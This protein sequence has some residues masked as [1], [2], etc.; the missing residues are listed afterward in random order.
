MHFLPL[1]W[2]Y[3]YEIRELTSKFKAASYLVLLLTNKIAGPSLFSFANTLIVLLISD[4][5]FEVRR[6]P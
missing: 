3:F 2:Y 1:G 5:I 6:L 4:S